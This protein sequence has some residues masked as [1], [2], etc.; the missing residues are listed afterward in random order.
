MSR[1]GKI[2]KRYADGGRPS[3]SNRKILKRKPQTLIKMSYWKTLK[4]GT[5]T[6]FPDR[7]GKGGQNLPN[8]QIMLPDNLRL[9]IW[10]NADKGYAAYHLV[11]D[12]DEYREHVEKAQKEFAENLNAPQLDEST[13]SSLNPPSPAPADDD[14]PF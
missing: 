13:K 4:K 10:L 5:V 6:I 3:A 11:E 12:T 14:L 2:R 9:A 7:P 8:I 1:L